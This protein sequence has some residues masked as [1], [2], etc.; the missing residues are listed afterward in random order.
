MDFFENLS[1][2][3]FFKLAFGYNYLGMYFERSGEHFLNYTYN[4]FGI[5]ATSN[6]SKYFLF[7]LFATKLPIFWNTGFQN[8]L[9]RRNFRYLDSPIVLEGHGI[10]YKFCKY[11][12]FS[13]I[14]ENFPNGC[15][16]RDVRFFCKE[17][18]K[19]FYKDSVTHVNLSVH[20][21]Y[22]LSSVKTQNLINK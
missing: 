1:N 20:Q 5:H 15:S 10:V 4:I 14:F 12:V 16:F 6:S 17:K 9:I 7:L 2:K 19:M 3:L 22:P 21:H 11:Y 18:S 8:K 13:N